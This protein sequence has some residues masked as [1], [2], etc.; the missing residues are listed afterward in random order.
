MNNNRSFAVDARLLL[1]NDAKSPCIVYHFQF[2][3][4]K[5]FFFKPCNC[6]NLVCLSSQVGITILRYLLFFNTGL[7][8]KEQRFMMKKKNANVLY[9]K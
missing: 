5:H 7:F 9:C 8:L 2:S 1:T 4:K 6:C 3:E